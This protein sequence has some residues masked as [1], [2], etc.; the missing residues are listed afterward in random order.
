MKELKEQPNCWAVIAV[1]P[2]DE[3]GRHNGK[4]AIDPKQIY[5]QKL[6]L[7]GSNW[8]KGWTSYQEAVQALDYANKHLHDG[9]WNTPVIKFTLA[10]KITPP[11]IFID[12]DDIDGDPEVSADFKELSKL[13]GGTYCE[14]SQS[15]KGLHFLARGHIEEDH[16]KRNGKF[17]IYT[18]GRYCAFTGQQISKSDRLAELDQD[19]IHKVLEYGHVLKAQKKP[20]RF[21]GV[22]DNTKSL[23]ISIPQVV[24]KMLDSS[25]GQRD[26][27]FMQG[28]W[29]EKYESQ[30]EA[31]LAFCNDLA[32]WTGKDP[33]KMDEIFRSSSLMRPKW[34]E[35]HGENTYGVMTMAK[36]IKDTNK[37]YQPRS[38]AEPFVDKQFKF[39]TPTQNL[40]V[41]DT[42]HKP[43]ENPAATEAR[44]LLATLEFTADGNVK[45]T[46]GNISKI[47]EFD[48][49][50]KGLFRFNA[51]TEDVDVMKNLT[52]TIIDAMKAA[53][54][55]I[56]NNDDISNNIKL[57]F[58]KG[59]LTDS[60]ANSLMLYCDI[61]P[62]YHA[63][64][65]KD[66]VFAGI[67][68]TAHNHEYNPM[69]D[70]L[71]K[72][73]ADW[74]GISRIFSI[75]PDYLGAD[76]TPENRLIAKLFFLGV[77]AKIFD[78]STK[79]DYVLDLVGGQGVGKTTLLRKLAPQGAYRDGF[80]DFTYKD[81]ILSMRRAVIVNDDEMVASNKVSFEE[82][83]SFITESDFEIREPYAHKA[84][85]FQKK[86]VLCRTTNEIRHLKDKSGD[87]RF[88]SIMCHPE[89]QKRHPVT[90]LDKDYINQLW[91]EAV[92]CYESYE[93]K[94]KIFA[95][96]EEQNELLE[97]SRQEF[98][99]TTALEDD[100]LDALDNKFADTDFIKTTTLWDYF[101]NDLE[102][103]LTRSDKASIKYN[104][105]HLGW[106]EKVK[107]NNG[108]T[109][110][111]FSR[112]K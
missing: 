56:E 25:K 59:Y 24:E 40:T 5:E 26:N 19:A 65:K 111:G 69:V 78:P 16:G 100:L 21:V 15:G 93:D 107:K 51:F 108:H 28:G 110:R 61:F 32:F 50:L 96:T 35:L 41:V 17:E 53:G 49:Q 94:S 81:N 27:L 45:N 7:L 84:T 63:N 97:K 74:D 34:D 98:M 80:T 102:Y 68:V 73:R 103:R 75:F 77:V 82:I 9:H 44:K 83:K 12:V 60:V 38:D 18:N 2:P 86:F 71:A 13:T 8:T 64:F 90:D 105:S 46:I 95:L 30:S 31:D 37:T 52:F 33:K 87:R 88:N 67:D 48:P 23:P 36:A 3:E 89:K 106:E 91:G 58:K 109:E 42:D 79:Y 62:K 20:A 39:N 104:M 10:L 57:R 112:I 72:C 22:A 85:H 43:A 101:E 99:Y 6:S 66:T 54:F 11:L 92:A 4:L 14:V 47:L 1:T 29:E 76:D 55:A 70:Y